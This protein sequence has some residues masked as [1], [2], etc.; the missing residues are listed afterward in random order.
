MHIRAQQQHNYQN[1][2]FFFVVCGN[3]DLIYSL[4]CLLQG[5]TSLELTMILLPQPPES[6]DYRYLQLGLTIKEFRNRL[7]DYINGGVSFYLRFY[8]LYPQVSVSTGS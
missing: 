6:W 7:G 2:I 1:S 5:P 4:E 8:S 3:R